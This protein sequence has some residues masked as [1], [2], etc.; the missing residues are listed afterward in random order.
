MQSSCFESKSITIKLPLNCR[1]RYTTSWALDARIRHNRRHLSG[2]FSSPTSKGYNPRMWRNLI[3]LCGSLPV[4]LVTPDSSCISRWRFMDPRPRRRTNPSK[5][6]QN[7]DRRLLKKD[8]ARTK[9]ALFDTSDTHTMQHKTVL[10]ALCFAILLHYSFGNF[11]LNDFAN[12]SRDVVLISKITRSS[13]V[14]RNKWCR[15]YGMYFIRLAL[16]H[17]ALRITTIRVGRRDLDGRW[18]LHRLQFRW[19]RRAEWSDHHR[20]RSG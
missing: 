10:I 13:A 18:N 16:R 4:Y 1:M 15:L 19:T 9:T 6:C 20:R 14:P 5:T 2:W 8:Q 7:S 11:K 12:I 17:P 3:F